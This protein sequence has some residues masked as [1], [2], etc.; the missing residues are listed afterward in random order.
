MYVRMIYKIEGIL[1]SW[2]ARGNKVQYKN[3]NEYQEYFLG[4]KTAGAWGWQPYQPAN[5]LKIW[6]PQPPGTLRDCPVI[7]RDW[8]L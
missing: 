5:C 6:D 2:D 4:V 7:Y 8:L 1:K 3:G